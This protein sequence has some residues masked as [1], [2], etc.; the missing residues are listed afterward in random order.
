MHVEFG[1]CIQLESLDQLRIPYL[2][3][4]CSF[5]DPRDKHHI[6]DLVEFSKRGESH[7]LSVDWILIP[8]RSARVIRN[9]DSQPSTEFI[10]DRLAS[11]SSMWLKEAVFR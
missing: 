5:G 1:F 2:D 7:N 11:L 4:L 10:V 9:Q 6:L 8:Q 3:Q